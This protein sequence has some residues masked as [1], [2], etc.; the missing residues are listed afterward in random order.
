MKKN[1]LERLESEG[2]PLIEGTRVTFYWQGE[3]APCLV[4]D[5]HGWSECGRTLGPVTAKV[6]AGEGQPLW[7]SSYSLPRD[8]YVEYYFYD[9][10]AD[11]RLMDPFNPRTV[12]NGMGQRNNFFYMPE[13]APTP[14]VERRSGIKHGT[15]T[16]R[17]VETGFLVDEGQREVHFYAPAVKGR[18][19]LLVVYDGTDYLQRGRLVNIVDNLI[20]EGRMR[21]VALA[22]LQNGG[23]RR[24]VEYACSDATIDWLDRFVLPMAAEQLNL[25]SPRR[26]RGAYGVLGA[27][28]GGLMSLYT[29]LRMPEV[30]GK[31]ICQSGT[32][33]S[34]GR[35][36]AAVDLIR[37]GHAHDK[38]KIWMDVGR[39]DTLLEDNRRMRPLLKKNGYDLSYREFS[40][41][42]CY[43]AWRD[44]VW[45]ALEEL[46]P[47]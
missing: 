9:A 15:V 30:F 17:M 35:D 24:A 31:V 41:G 32:F 34:G 29:G 6:G 12:N 5:V 20:A 4:D 47:A 10:E 46:F 25:V 26:N 37:H 1:I 22:M 45:R 43:T 44:D 19:P 23:R 14:L 8:A 36:F 16:R 21:P 3:R 27:S 42:H 13:A 33:E 18:V 38:L 39:L 40:A 11:E 2:N 7:S 28:F